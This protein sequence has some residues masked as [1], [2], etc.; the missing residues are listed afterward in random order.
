M[1]LTSTLQALVAG[2]RRSAQDRA[3]RGCFVA[4]AAAAFGRGSVGVGVGDGGPRG[5][6]AHHYCASAGAAEPLPTGG[7]TSSS[8][9]ADKVS[10]QRRSPD[11]QLRARLAA[12]LPGRVSESHSVLQ[13]HGRDESYHEPLPPD[14]VVYPET[15]EECAQAVSACAQARVPV[16]PFGAGTSVE[17]HVG[18][19]HGGVCFDMGRM[20]RVLEVAAADMDCRV[21]ARARQ[22]RAGTVATAHMSASGTGCLP[23]YCTRPATHAL[24]DACSNRGVSHA[25]QHCL[26]RPTHIVCAWACPPRSPL[27]SITWTHT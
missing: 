21:Q 27:P 1:V 6:E 13:Q 2:A 17:G 18:A 23:A 11:A 19:L 25:C 14:L 15:T 5:A 26:S 22:S 9:L 4:A 16:I 24:P 10:H 12:L 3:L 8:G 7:A 20:N